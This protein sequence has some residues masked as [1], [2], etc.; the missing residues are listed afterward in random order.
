MRLISGY[1]IADAG[2]VNNVAGLR[3]MAI[4]KWKPKSQ[5][6]DIRFVDKD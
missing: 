6:N 1:R 4:P 3:L 5:D 2:G